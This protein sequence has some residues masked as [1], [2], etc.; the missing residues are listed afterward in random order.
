[1]RVVCRRVAFSLE[2]VSTPILRRR[3]FGRSRCGAADEHLMR[4]WGFCSITACVHRFIH[5]AN[6][7]AVTGRPMRGRRW[8]VREFARYGIRWRSRRGRAG[9]SGRDEVASVLSWKTRVLT[10]RE[11]RRRSDVYM[12]TFVTK[13]K[14][15]SQCCLWVMRMAIRG[16]YRIGRGSWWAASYAPVVGR[17][18]WT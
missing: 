15:R 12:G 6:S 16:C 14:S 18:R 8:C 5:M 4:G 1:V 3:S 11:V 2:G 9:G 13:T 7:A 10:V 17:V